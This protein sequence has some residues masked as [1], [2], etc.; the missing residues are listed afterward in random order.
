LSETFRSVYPIHDSAIGV[1]VCGTTFL[2]FRVLCGTFVCRLVAAVGMVSFPLYLYHRPIVGV[3][4]FFLRKDLGSGALEPLSIAVL[5]VASIICFFLLT[6][7]LGVRKPR[8]IALTLGAETWTPQPSRAPE[9]R[10]GSEAEKE[11][12]PAAA[13][14]VAQD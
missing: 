8:L 14:T 2:I 5:S 1:V 7:Q 6:L 9:K 13:E 11:S 3:I 12:I 10:R 4:V